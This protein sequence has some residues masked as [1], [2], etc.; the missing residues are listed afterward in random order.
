MEKKKSIYH[1]PLLEEMHI[2]GLG[3]ICTSLK[4]IEEVDD[5]FEE[6]ES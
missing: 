6:V 5:A 4:Q 3:L 2:L 1:E